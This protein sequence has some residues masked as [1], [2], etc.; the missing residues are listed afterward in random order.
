MSNFC[1]AY[2]DNGFSEDQD[3]VIYLKTGADAS[4]A[5][6]AA[7]GLESLSNVAPPG[8]PAA[9]SPLA[10]D[11]KR[12]WW[13]QTKFTTPLAQWG[14]AEAKFEDHTLIVLPFVDQ[15]RVKQITAWINGQPVEVQAYRYPRNR[16]MMCRWIDIIGAAIRPGANDLVLQLEMD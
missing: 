8:L 1:G 16:A 4:P 9:T 5:V 13:L 6:P 14:G 11:A 2:L 10:K 15:N 12:S 3:T 7:T